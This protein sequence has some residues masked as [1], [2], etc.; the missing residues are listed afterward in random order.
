MAALDERP[1]ESGAR[2]REQLE[3]LEA[4]LRG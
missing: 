1:I 2:L 4:K 3:Q